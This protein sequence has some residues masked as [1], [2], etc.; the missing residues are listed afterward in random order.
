MHVYQFSYKF[1]TPRSCIMFTS[2]FRTF[3]ILAVFT[4]FFTFLSP[5]LLA[6]KFCDLLSM[7]Y[8]FLAIYGSEFIFSQKGDSSSNQP[9]NSFLS[10]KPSQFSVCVRMCQ[11]FVSVPKQILKVGSYVSIIGK[12]LYSFVR[13]VLPLFSSDQLLIKM[14]SLTFIF[15]QQKTPKQSVFFKILQYM[16]LK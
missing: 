5:H 12:Q 7:C 1:L 15:Y 11:Y 14:S 4:N 8:N 9:S 6:S 10:K 16:I 2:I 13:G 3:S